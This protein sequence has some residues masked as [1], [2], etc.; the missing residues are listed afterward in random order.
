MNK[1]EVMN[2][3]NIQWQAVE[4]AI[5]N[6]DE[7]F[8]VLGELLNQK[9]ALLYANKS[10]EDT[11]DFEQL[12]LNLTQQELATYRNSITKILQDIPP[13]SPYLYNQ[14][15]LINQTSL[16]YINELLNTTEAYL[17]SM[18][19]NLDKDLEE[20]LTEDYAYAYMASIYLMQK[21]LGQ[22]EPVQRLSNETLQVKVNQADSGVPYKDTLFKNFQQSIVDMKRA[23]TQ[24]IQ[25]QKPYKGLAKDIQARANTMASQSRNVYRVESAYKMARASID[26]YKDTNVTQYQIVGTLDSRTTDTCQMADGEVHNIEE[27]VLGVNFP[28]L[29]HYH[30]NNTF[31]QC[32]S[33]TIPLVDTVGS[34]RARN[35]YTNQNYLVDS[36]I[37][38]QEWEFRY[39]S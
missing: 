35:P 21:E 34:R 15:K 32:R 22:F 38:F 11:E 17:A 14:A 6:I 37:T 25:A 12:Y 3:N 13:D 8:N 27:A 18:Y 28:P 2:L 20:L 33:T 29:I 19:Y 4:E 30:G 26:S 39:Y 23:I 16:T 7:A 10:V 5:N 1:Q 9:V 24:G 31:H 36:N